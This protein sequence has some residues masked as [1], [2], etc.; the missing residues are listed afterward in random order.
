[1]GYLVFG[2][3]VINGLL[4]S[5]YFE[6]ERNHGGTALI[7]FNLPVVALAVLFYVIVRITDKR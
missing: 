1:M 2:Y 5:Y 3:F 6:T 7:L 4:L